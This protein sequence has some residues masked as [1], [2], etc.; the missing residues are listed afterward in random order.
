M[1]RLGFGR[2]TWGSERHR[3]A[4]P[5]GKAEGYWRDEGVK[6]EV[7]VIA[8]DRVGP[9][10]AGPGI[11]AVELARALAE[12]HSVRLAAPVGSEP[13]DDGMPF[14]EFDGAR[15]GTI[16]EA[17][18]GAE[19]VFS[20]PLPPAVARCIEDGSRRWVVDLYNPEPF[21]GLEA[22]RLGRGPLHRRALDVVRIDRLLFAAQTGSA[23]V[24]ANERQR[25]MWLGF[26]AAERRLDSGRYDADPEGRNLIETVP[27]GVP[28]EPPRP[29]PAL[30]RGELF[31]A[32]ARIL[33][34]GGG[35]WDWLDPLTVLR[36]LSILRDGDRRWVCAF[37]GT[38]RPVGGAHFK[39]GEQTTQLAEDLGL[40]EAGAVKFVDW[41]PYAARGGPLLEADAAVCAHLRTMETRFAVRTRLFDALWARLPIVSTDGDHWSDLVRARGLGAIAP[42]E[43]PKA[44]AAAAQV[45]VERGRQHY[46]P[47]LEALAE[48]H[49]WPRV[50]GPLAR[51]IDRA[52]ELPPAAAPLG[53][54]LLSARHT[55]AQRVNRVRRLL[56]RR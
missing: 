39:I 41:L 21:E 54:R 2:F 4:P 55:T 25:D 30:L 13:I 50:A 51:L 9:A 24:C 5:F 12:H 53:A 17:L 11:R 15:G 56:G 40:T 36:A 29:G 10:M 16:R 23:F 38:V 1:G 44:L 45:V 43:Q 20:D 6:R 48:E 3:P 28:A 14:F 33:L 49:R 35:L 8:H 7:L 26:L 34:W 19:V 42:P 32:D 31:G 22:H 37:I 52:G 46:A 18:R 27:F 47:A